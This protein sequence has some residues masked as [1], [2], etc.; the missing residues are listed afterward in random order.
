MPLPKMKTGEQTSTTGTILL[1]RETESPQNHKTK[2][3][4]MK[5]TPTCQGGSS[6]SSEIRNKSQGKQDPQSASKARLT[7]LR[8]KHSDG[9]QSEQRSAS[10]SS[11]SSPPKAPLSNSEQT[12]NTSP[13]Q[14]GL[15]PTLTSTQTKSSEEDKKEGA[16]S[17]II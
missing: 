16:D 13:S 8:V 4:G 1:Q 7:K 17:G 12:A 14:S 5:M 2:D 6:Q 11:K 3:H 9:F 15:Y 10:K